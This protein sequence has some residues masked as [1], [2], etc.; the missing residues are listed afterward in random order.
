MSITLSPWIVLSKDN[1]V[2]VPTDW[3]V[4]IVEPISS[5][6]QMYEEKV[7]VETEDD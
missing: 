2:P 1:Q 6:T 4:T 3:I 7:G 5:V